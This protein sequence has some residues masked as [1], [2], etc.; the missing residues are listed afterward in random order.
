LPQVVDLTARQEWLFKAAKMTIWFTA[1]PIHFS[2]NILFTIEES[3]LKSP[4]ERTD[5]VEARYI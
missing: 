5:F 4:K 3:H 1:E 2:K